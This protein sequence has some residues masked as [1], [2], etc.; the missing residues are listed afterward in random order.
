MNQAVSPSFPQATCPSGYFYPQHNGFQPRLGIVF[1]ATDHTV[2][3][4]AFAML[5]DHNNSLA[6]ENQDERLSWPT[7]ID[8]TVTNQ[9]R[10]LPD[11]YLNAFPAA[12]SFFSGGNA[13]PFASYAANPHNKIPYSLEYNLGVEHQLN[14]SSMFM[15]D[16]V[17]SV[18]RHLFVN[19]TGNTAPTPGPGTVKSREPYPQYGGPFPFDLN[20]GYSNYNGLQAQFKESL[21]RGLFFNVSYTYSKAMDVQSTAQSASPENY[22]NLAQNYGPADFD[23]RHIFVVSGVYSLPFGR[24]KEYLNNAPEIVQA[25]AG[26]W[27]LGAIGSLVSGA[28]FNAL[29]G[30]D[31]ANVGGSNQRAQRTGANPYLR[32][33]FTAASKPWLNPAGFALPASYTW[34]SETRND[35]VG[36][37]SK[38]LDLSVFKDIPLKER[39]KLQFRAEFFNVFNHSNYSTPSSTV[40]SSS[41]GLITSTASAG[42]DLQFALKVMF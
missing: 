32:G 9:N 11:L 1:K 20:E 34:G 7:S 38:D 27:N 4:T 5:D 25:V 8:A 3:R 39:L 29:A 2:I 18:S 12:S 22:Y 19:L 21:S 14:R 30:S 16:Y 37:P 35:L 26:N 40:T 31:V 10:G 28:P 17:G 36:P 24:G 42:R 41:F 6:Q 13:T 33:K 23:R 15:I